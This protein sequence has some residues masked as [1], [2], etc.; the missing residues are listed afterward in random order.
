MPLA[1]LSVHAVHVCHAGL[2]EEKEPRGPQ[3]VSTVNPTPTHCSRSIQGPLGT[4]Q[5]PWR[6]AQNRGGTPLLLAR[7]TAAPRSSSSSQIS[8]FPLPA[9]AVRARQRGKRGLSVG[10]ERGPQAPYHLQ[11]WCPCPL[12]QGGLCD[13][14][15][16]LSTAA[17][18]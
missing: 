14:Q 18:H 11:C 8:T 10:A 2:R 6:A 4:C 3:V 12:N 17:C 13:G 16:P 5:W 1:W 7:D 15:D 9:A